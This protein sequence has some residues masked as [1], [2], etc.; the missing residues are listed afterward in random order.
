MQK[1]ISTE[2]KNEVI[3]FDAARFPYFPIEWFDS[4][5]LAQNAL[6]TGSAGGRGTTYFFHVNDTDLVLRRYKRGGLPGK[7]LNDQFWYLGLSRTRA[8]RELSL[9]LQLNELNLPAPVPVAARVVKHGFYYQS[10]IITER[11]ASAKD[12]HNLLLQSALTPSEWEKIGRTIRQFHDCQVYHHDLNIHNI[13]MNDQGRIFLI[14]FDKCGFKHGE[15]WKQAN[16][17]RLLRSLR[18]ESQ[19]CEHYFFEEEDWNNLING[20]NSHPLK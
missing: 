1:R 19:R 13:M 7:L 11:L 18:K 17:S 10:D 5:Y 12:V 9:L 8:W 2:N 6:L 16:L 14:D 3:W 20:Y 15:K 4:A